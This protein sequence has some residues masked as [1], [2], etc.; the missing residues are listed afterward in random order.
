MMAAAVFQPERWWMKTETRGPGIAGLVE[1]Q[2]SEQPPKVYE[3]LLIEPP[4][5]VLYPVISATSML[6]A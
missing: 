4:L 5:A 6:P 3:K 2:R 1:P